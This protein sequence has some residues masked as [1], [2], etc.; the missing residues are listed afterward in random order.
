MLQILVLNRDHK[1][2]LPLFGINK[3][4]IEKREKRERREISFKPSI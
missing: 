1:K 2:I 4:K 3:K